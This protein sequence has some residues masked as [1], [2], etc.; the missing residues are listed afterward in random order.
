MVEE[1][2][3]YAPVSPGGIGA[4]T[5]V[6]DLKEFRV[7]VS[8]DISG[9]VPRLRVEAPIVPVVV[10]D[11][12]RVDELLARADPHTTFKS[13]EFQLDDVVKDF[14][15]GGTGNILLVNLTG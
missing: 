2:G 4:E 6:R 10:A 11:P 5:R 7:G 15:V 1:A 3:H 14:L 8:L 9:P 12:P 13:E